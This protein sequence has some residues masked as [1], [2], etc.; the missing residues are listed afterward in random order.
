MNNLNSDEIEFIKNMFYDSDYRLYHRKP[1]LNNF[2]N[3]IKYHKFQQ[4]E[5]LN[6]PLINFYNKDHEIIGTANYEIIGYVQNEHFIW[7]WGYNKNKNKNKNIIATSIRLLD[8]AIKDNQIFPNIK[9]LLLNRTFKI[10]D[11]I[12]INFIL[13]LILHLIKYA[14]YLLNVKELDIDNYLNEY[15]STQ[16]IPKSKF[17]IIIIYGTK[18]Y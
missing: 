17:M 9:K 2:F 8:Y 4:I 18:I 3:K 14:E 16:N 13:A 12:Q 1:D 10:I 11:N 5:N 7:A 6:K 15:T